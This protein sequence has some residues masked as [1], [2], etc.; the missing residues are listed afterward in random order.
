MN[1]IIH[2]YHSRCHSYIYH[3]D[4]SFEHFYITFGLDDLIKSFKEPHEILHKLPFSFH[5]QLYLESPHIE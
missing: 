5:S 4:L 3:S 1:D 2:N